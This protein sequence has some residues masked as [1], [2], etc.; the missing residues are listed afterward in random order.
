MK[1]IENEINRILKAV[2]LIVLIFLTSYK[3]DDENDINPLLQY[4]ISMEEPRCPG[5]CQ[6]IIR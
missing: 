6:D 3:E 2:L 1:K 4:S 5:G